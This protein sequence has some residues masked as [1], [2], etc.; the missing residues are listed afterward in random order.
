MSRRRSLTERV[1]IELERRL[2]AYEQSVAKQRGGFI[3]EAV[4]GP[5]GTI[6]YL[7]EWHGLTEFG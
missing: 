6:D 2:R 3:L 7:P 5:N 1:M 4:P